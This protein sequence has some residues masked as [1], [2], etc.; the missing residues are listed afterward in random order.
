M[1]DELKYVAAGEKTLSASITSSQLTVELTDLNSRA[2]DA[3]VMDD[4]GVI[5]YATLEPGGA[6]MELISFD[7]ISGTQL[8]GVIRGLKFEAPYDTDLDLRKAHAG[9]AT[10]VFSNSPQLYDKFTSKD[11][12]ETINGIWT[13]TNPNYPRM[14]SA[15]PAATDDEQ[16]VTK[17]MLDDTAI[18]GAPDATEIAKGVIEVATQAETESGAIAG[19]GSTTADLAVTASKFF[20]TWNRVVTTEFTY[21]DTISIGDI[22]YVDTADSKWKLAS[23]SVAL[24]ADNTYGVAMDAGV[25]TDT[26]K[27][28]I[29][30]GVTQPNGITAAGIQFVS[31]IAGEVSN[32]AGTYSKVIGFAPTATDMILA[33][34]QRVEELAGASVNF[35]TA[36]L[37]A[38]LAYFGASTLQQSLK[39]SLTMAEDVAMGDVLCQETGG[40]FKSRITD[41]GDQVPGPVD[42]FTDN[43]FQENTQFMFPTTRTNNLRQVLVYMNRQDFTFDRIN[44]V[45]VDF[46]TDLK[47]IAGLIDNF[48]ST[49]FTSDAEDMN[50]KLLTA[51][52]VIIA[53]GD[54]DIVVS[55]FNQ[56]DGTPTEGAFL[57]LAASG[58][59][60]VAVA[61]HDPSS[62]VVFTNFI[63]SGIRTYK[64]TVAGNTLT[65]AAVGTFL[66]SADD[67]D[68]IDAV[69]FGTS[70]FYAVMYDNDTSTDGEVCIGEY[71]EG[72]GQWTTSGTPVAFDGSGAD[73]K[74]G[75]IYSLDDTRA[76]MF[77]VD[78]SS[79]K[80]GI[81]T[82]SGTSASMSGVVTLGGVR[83]NAA[84]SVSETGNNQFFIASSNSTTS[85]IYWNV[86]VN[87]DFDGVTEVD[88]ATF[89]R[90]SNNHPGTSVHALNHKLAWQAYGVAAEDNEAR[91]FEIDNNY[92][93]FLGVADEDIDDTTAG[94]VITDG[95]ATNGLSGLT[96]G[97]NYVD[98]G[99]KFTPTIRDQETPVIEAVATSS[100]EISIK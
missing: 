55:A 26:A 100:T 75:R 96:I 80:A 97:P 86:T 54:D 25:D 30:Q 34:V 6:N 89:T 49:G 21:G 70:D 48:V 66:A 46:A 51:N 4:F 94:A 53:S 11:N 17:K 24:T 91:F 82:R 15:A 88:S 42:S 12:D 44:L 41:F 28:V 72:T 85:T 9:G 36:N 79:A 77:W 98:N 31:D 74:T 64:V 37:E 99:G 76:V 93:G 95:F 5:G 59:K 83:T 23:G 68:I 18:A 62:T 14:D 47:S 52:S 60:T 10:L 45:A 33:S 29:I 19:S 32:A 78:G 3:L 84:L 73:G 56:L 71:N 90:G 57:I 69:R 39:T 43:G 67:L 27:R 58:E 40:I 1:A 50:A 7:G 2:G 20:E 16:L 92:D 63:G 81:L 65:N 61:V 87:R 38:A 13:F 22:L 35:T 8:T